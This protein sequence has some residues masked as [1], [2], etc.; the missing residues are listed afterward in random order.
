MSALPRGRL[1]VKPGGMRLPL[2]A[3][4]EQTNAAEDRTQ[5]KC[6]MVQVAQSR[7]EEWL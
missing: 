7:G 6:L 3:R 5:D 1:G 2:G 4:Q